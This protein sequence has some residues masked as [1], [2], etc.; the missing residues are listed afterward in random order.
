MQISSVMTPCPYTINSSSSIDEALEM[1]G[2]RGIRHLPVVENGD[3]L[4]VLSERDI[5]VAKNVCDTSGYCPLVGDICQKEPLVAD[6]DASVG[7]VAAEMAE[8]KADVALISD[9]EG[10]FLGIFT[11]TDAY[12]VLAMLVNEIAAEQP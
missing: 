7:E 10:N 6:G 12:R 1:M 2:V 9:A 8:E 3:L 4:G 5:A 11:N